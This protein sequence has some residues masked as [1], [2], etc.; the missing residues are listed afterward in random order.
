MLKYTEGEPELKEGFRK[1][2]IVRL[3]HCIAKNLH[4][5]EDGFTLPLLKS[6]F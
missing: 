4:N 2:S 5:G 1:A 3:K 6:T